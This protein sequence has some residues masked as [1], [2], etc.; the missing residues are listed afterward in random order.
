MKTRKIPLV[1][2]SLML[3]L[4]VSAQGT[5]EDYQRAFGIGSRYSWKMKN[6]DVNVH[7]K[8]GTHQFWYSV[9]DGKGQVYKLVDA[10][11]NTV[12]VLTEN[13]EKPRQRPQ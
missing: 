13:P 10:D 3:T 11:K 8:R 1:L 5:K 6:G 7:L 2:L 4:S 9:Y 12:E